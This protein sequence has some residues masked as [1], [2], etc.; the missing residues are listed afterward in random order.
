M[1]DAEL[2]LG[3]EEFGEP[4]QQDGILFVGVGGY[5]QRIQSNDEGCAGVAELHVL[6]DHGARFTRVELSQAE[7]TFEEPGAQ[8]VKLG[9]KAAKSGVGE[10]DG[11][12]IG[13]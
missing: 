4:K 5:Q 2:V 9:L 6:G 1:A 13:C 11:E 3:D 7:S 10:R 12:G 8:A